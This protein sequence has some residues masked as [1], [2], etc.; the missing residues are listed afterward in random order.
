M[1][2]LSASQENVGVRGIMEFPLVSF[3]VSSL[4]YV[5]PTG[6]AMEGDT[7]IALNQHARGLFANFW[8]VPKSVDL[9]E[10]ARA[11]LGSLA[12]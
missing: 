9:S 10:N 8:Q 1:W 7:L 12:K 6:L 3:G 11:R 2:S 4:S 5:G